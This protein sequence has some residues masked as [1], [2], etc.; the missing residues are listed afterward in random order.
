MTKLLLFGATGNL[1]KEIAKIAKEQGYDLTVVVRNKDKAEL[2]TN[3]TNKFVVADITDL[4][5]LTNI[6][7]GFDIVISALG[8]SVSPNDNS[9]P[10]FNDIDL[11]A[12]SNILDIAKKK[13]CEEICLCFCLSFR[14]ILAFRIF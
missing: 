7:S 2:L 10:S 9:K 6:C 1:G 11:I 3:I 5:T 14:K 12:N 13:W 8:K 4:S